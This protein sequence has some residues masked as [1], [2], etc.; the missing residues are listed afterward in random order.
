M[1]KPIQDKRI[2]PCPFCGSEAYYGH[3]SGSSV[4]VMCLG[5]DCHV[6]ISIEFPHYWDSEISGD[7]Y[8]CLFNESLKRW[9]RRTK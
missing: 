7:L 9:N 6:E 5:E 4:G 8:E 2:K 3:T 1:I